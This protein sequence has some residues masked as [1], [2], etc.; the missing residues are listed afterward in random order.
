M[1][2]ELHPSGMTWERWNSPWRTESERALAVAY[3]K[4]IERTDAKQNHENFYNKL[5]EALW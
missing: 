5:E 1:K 3:N 4:K 2:Q